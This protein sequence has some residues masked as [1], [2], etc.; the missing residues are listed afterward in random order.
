MTRDPSWPTLSASLYY[1]DAAAAIDFLCRAF[2]FQVRLKIDTEDG[3]IRHS[4]LTLDD[5]LIM[6]GSARRP[7]AGRVSPRAIGGQSTGDLMIFVSDVDAHC[8]RARAAGAKILQ[9]PT[10]TDYGADYWADRSYEAQ[11]PEG[12]RFYFSQR[13]RNHGEPP[14]PGVPHEPA[15]DL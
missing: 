3:D 7:G 15:R 9:E 11:D 14:L 1:E 2:G 5:A 12:H 6:V 8:A 10:T 13:V 4:E